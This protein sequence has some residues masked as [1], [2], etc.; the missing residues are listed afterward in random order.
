MSSWKLEDGKLLFDVEIPNNTTAVV[1]IP[2][3]NVT[4]SGKPLDEAEKV[5]LIGKEEGYV[6]VAVGSGYYRFAGKKL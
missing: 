4:E 5:K 3:T 2:A 1:Y 6:K